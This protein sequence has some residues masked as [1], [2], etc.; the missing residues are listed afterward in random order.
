MAWSSPQSLY[1]G[2]MLLAHVSHYLWVLY[3]PPVLI[4]IASIVW[5]VVSERRKR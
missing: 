2:G 4:V 3:L 5:T 1:P